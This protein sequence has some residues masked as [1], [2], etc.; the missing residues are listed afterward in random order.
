MA[1]ALRGMTWN[2]PRGHDPLVA[3]SAAW[4]DLTGVEILWDK[5]SLQDFES[6][7]V[8]E[9][10]KRYDLIVIDHPHVGQITAENCLLPLDIPGREAECEAL[11]EASV[12]P[13]WPSYA[14]RGRQW[15]LPI[16]AATQVQ[17][18]RPD[19]I[20]GPVSDWSEMLRLARDGAVLCPM[21]PPHGL[22]TLY[23][24]S[25]N[26]GRPGKVDG[27]ALFDREGG[28][29]A[30]ALIRELVSLTDPAC[31][32]MD[33]IAVFE[34][35]SLA[36]SR[37]ACSPLIYGYVS[38]ARAGFRP[39]LIRFADIPAA[40]G[41][42]PV[43]SALGG[44]GVAVS[45]FS[46]HAE[47]AIDFAFHVASG[48]VQKGLYAASGGQPGHSDAWRDADVNAATADFYLDTRAT[49][50]GAWL[51]PRH[52]G[53][54]RFQQQASVRLNEG[55]AA[56]EGAAGVIDALNVLH[57]ASLAATDSPRF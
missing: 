16:D 34:R 33:P 26:L 32:Q 51:R 24:L 50:D 45:A 1:T 49:L 7:P 37:I 41:D 5:R 23:T 15:A 14:W 56:G 55:L 17:A 18:W 57:R 27:D 46:R 8:E 21:R 39:A 6:F 4:K 42:G 2:H 52:N 19:L 9:L 53:Y 36:E 29:R 47:A 48:F 25:A 10:A 35:M 31:Y 28:E 22:M 40:G 30:I 13:S 12:G 38:Y 20:D 3:V 11:R 54:M 44:T 43:G